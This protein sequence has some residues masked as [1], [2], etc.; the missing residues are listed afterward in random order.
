MPHGEL[1]G[2]VLSLPMFC[3]RLAGGHGRARR[4]GS[5]KFSGRQRH[6]PGR[7]A[8]GGVQLAPFT[9]AGSS[10]TPGGSAVRSASGVPAGVKEGGRSWLDEEGRIE[11]ASSRRHGGRA[12]GGSGGDQ[13]VSL[14]TPCPL[15][16]PMPQCW[17][18]LP[19]CLGRA[20]RPEMELCT[21]DPRL[22]ASSLPPRPTAAFMRWNRP[23]PAGAASCS[24][25]PTPALPS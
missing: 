3:R 17:A 18:C 22:P 10:I 12:A 20:G 16:Q 6:R 9:G 13:C 7:M 19:G 14:C 11:Q 8:G 25:P 24:G 15:H 21:L 1:V 4:A 23:S 2:A 5:E